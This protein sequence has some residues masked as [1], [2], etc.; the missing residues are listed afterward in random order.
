M[1]DENKTA[2]K[3]TTEKVTTDSRGDRGE[4][5]TPT[6]GLTIR[7][8]WHAEAHG[9]SLKQFARKLLKEGDATAKEW[10]ANKRGA[11]NQ[12]RTDANIKAA[13]EARQATRAAK[14]KKKG[15]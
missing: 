4:V 13:T 3:A 2:E 9:G 7:Q 10:F 11:K 12:K 8:R 14:Q 15:N 6:A 1:S 5:G